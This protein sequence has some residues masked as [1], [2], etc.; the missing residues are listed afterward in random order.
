[1][2]TV[3]R[4]SSVAARMMRIAISLRLSARS[5]FIAAESILERLLDTFGQD[6]HE[7]LRIIAVH[8]AGDLAAPVH[9]DGGGDGCD[10]QQARQAI[11]EVYGDV[12]VALFEE[13]PDQLAV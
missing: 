6:I 5:F 10:S 3:R 11:L 9:D 1:M 8:A 12:P 2:A 13:R 4:P 7:A